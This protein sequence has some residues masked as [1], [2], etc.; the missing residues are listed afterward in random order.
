M[1]KTIQLTFYITLTDQ[2]QVTALQAQYP[3]GV[4]RG[5]LPAATEFSAPYQAEGDPITYPNTRTGWLPEGAA[6]VFPLDRAFFTINDGFW[7][8]L[9][10]RDQKYAW[11]GQFVYQAATT[12]EVDGTSGITAPGPLREVAFAQG[13]EDTPIGSSNGPEGQ[14][15]H[16]AVLSRDA[17]RTVDGLGFALRGD[18]VG[19]Q[20]SWSAFGGTPTSRGWERFYFRIRTLP[21]SGEC[22]IWR[23]RWAAGNWGFQLVIDTSGA[24]I[25]RNVGSGGAY[26]PVT[27]SGFMGSSEPVDLGVWHCLDIVYSNGVNATL[28]NIQSADVWID[29]E[30]AFAVDGYLHQEGAVT[31]LCGSSLLGLDTIGSS[32]NAEV[33]LDDH[34]GFIL[35]LPSLASNV[36]RNVYWTEAINPGL[37]WI[38]GHHLARVDAHVFDATHS[39]NWTGN[40][41]TLRQVGAAQQ[42]E[43]ALTSSTSGALIA[44]N[45]YGRL[46]A[47]QDR[48]LGWQALFVHVLMRRAT[49]GTPQLG[50]SYTETEGG[51]ATTVMANVGT[52]SATNNWNSTAARP[53]G[54]TTPKALWDL[55]LRFTKAADTNATQVA[56]LYGSLLLVGT[57][58]QCDIAPDPE[59]P[60][61]DRPVLAGSIAYG[62]HNAP[63]PRTPF[64]R[65]EVPP[66]A[67]VWVKAGTY[68]G[69]SLGQDVI[70]KIPAH[71]WWIR[72]TDSNTGAVRWW[73]SMTGAKWA[74]AGDTRGGMNYATEDPEYISA[75][76]DTDPESRSLLRVG[77]AN[78]AENVSAATYQYLAIGDPGMRF[79]LNAACRHNNAVTSF[80]NALIDAG[81]TPEWAFAVT[82]FHAGGGFLWAKGPG[83]P[84]NSGHRLDSATEQTTFGAFLA[85]VFRT[86]N[87]LHPSGATSLPFSLWRNRDGAD[88]DGL[89]LTE[90]VVVQISSYVGDGA[91]SR[92]LQLPRTSGKRPLWAIVVPITGNLAA[93]RDPSHTSNTSS[94]PASGSSTITT[95][96]TAGAVDSIT[97][98]STLNANGVAHSYLVVMA[99]DATAGNN[100]WGT[101]GEVLYDPVPAPGDEWPDGYTQ[102][103]LDDLENPPTDEG[104]DVDSFDDG[105]DLADDLADTVCVPFTLRACN[106]A[107]GRIG[108]SDILQAATDLTAPTS[109]EHT[110]LAQF[111]EPTLRRVLRDF[112]WPHATRYATPAR[113]DGSISDPVNADWVY[114]WRQP[115]GALFIRRI[116]RPELGRKFDQNPPPFRAAVDSIGPLLYTT[117]EG[118]QTDSNGDPFIEIEYTVRPN[119]GARAGGDQAFVSC[120]AWALA[121]ELAGPLARDKDT[122]ER[123]AKNYALERNTASTTASKERQNERPGDAPWLIDRGLP[124]DGNGWSR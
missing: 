28:G 15:S 47:Q 10:G 36:G 97:V 93:V 77:G 99:A 79:L 101:N 63:Y 118:V 55:M 103:E 33:D 78:A 73:S 17:S 89:G 108:V 52:P 67:P 56:S 74:V 29:H 31:R 117:D 5:P 12:Q 46:V 115:T 120:F 75:G 122:I 42:A 119:C 64:V 85:G 62:I 114:A 92:T 25:L 39:A 40:V 58:D 68:T 54:L 24:I 34:V 22:V 27:G 70:A 44:A 61:A 84:T 112:P 98:G 90:P 32:G 123:C 23:T 111:F 76:G 2:A 49:A 94:T 7:G 105:P 57:F 45:T 106:L 95:G 9:F 100:G 65:T 8:H 82:E 20:V 43:D 88:Y 109:R 91:A 69:N 116:I 80:D 26:F 121:G 51:S 18:S 96:I 1:A 102:D 21:Q 30:L 50:Y 13:F 6:G 35:P 14:S 87:T 59:N 66:D 4:S 71:F 48:S 3:N 104:G 124:G 16:S 60:D 11:I 110:L 83:H 53:T 19:A 41:R 37:D 72:R 113:I 38:N 81:F 86:L 107:L